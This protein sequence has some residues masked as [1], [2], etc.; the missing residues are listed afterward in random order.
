MR[1]LTARTETTSY[2]TFNVADTLRRLEALGH[3]VTPARRSVV[4]AVAAQPNRFTATALC[5]AVA[6]RSPTIGRA[7]VFRTLG[8]LVRVGVLERLHSA[9]G[10]DS[11]VVGERARHHHHLVCSSCGT[12]IDLEG[13]GLAE[14][15]ESVAHQHSFRVE[16]HLVEIFGLCPTCRPTGEGADR[17]ESPGFT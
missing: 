10:R 15:I 2:S 8:L 5:T 17:P 11:Y 13:C 14:L 16:G 3:G 4:E 12:V 6:H 9:G 1:T 7:T